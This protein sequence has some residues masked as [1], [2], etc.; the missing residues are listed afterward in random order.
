MTKTM[1]DIY[2]EMKREYTQAT[3]LVLNDSGDMALRL[4]AFAAQLHSLWAQAGWVRRQAFPQS[5]DG[6]YLERH[7][8]LRGIDRRSA[9]AA[10]GDIEFY[11]DEAISSALT[12]AKGTVCLTA[13]GTEFLTSESGRIGPGS[14]SCTLHAVARIAGSDGNVPAG[15]IVQ[16]ASP[17]PGVLGCVNMDG[18]SGGTDDEDDSSLRERVISSYR[19]LPNGANSAFYENQALSVD[20]VV[21]AAVLPRARGIGTVDIFIATQS[22]LPSEELI[23]QVA[24]LLDSQREICVD[25]CVAAPETVGV[26]I[27][28]KLEEDSGY[29]F[30]SVSAAVRAEI[31]K[32][33]SGSLLGSDILLARLG[34]IVFSVDGVRNYSLELPGADLPLDSIKLPILNS[35]EISRVVS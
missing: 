29:S 2:Q 3:G 31:E 8:Q 32:Y 27:S 14:L 16:M 35:L 28:L 12:I 25:I 17:P 10:E 19:S 5:A 9:T 1:D 34:S 23:D 30:D 11:I 13:A 4:R 26:D 6:E 21:K 24:Q 18:F 15:S 33:F 7:A 22:G 20:G